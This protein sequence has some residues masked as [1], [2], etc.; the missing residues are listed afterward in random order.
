M[1]HFLIF[2]VLCNVSLIFHTDCGS[3]S[4]ANSW[5]I[6]LGGEIKRQQELFFLSFFLIGKSAPFSCM[7]A[8]VQYWALSLWGVNY[9]LSVVEPPH[10]P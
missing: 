8:H 9:Y 5:Q 6:H 3:D 7:A 10:H 1:P 4:A 2:V